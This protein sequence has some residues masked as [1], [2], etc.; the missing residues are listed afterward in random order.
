MLDSLHVQQIM[1]LTRTS[2]QLFSRSSMIGD[3]LHV[4]LPFLL[5]NTVR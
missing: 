1:G 3:E 4:Q 2:G 5:Q